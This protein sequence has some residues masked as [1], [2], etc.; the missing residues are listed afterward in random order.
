[1]T[2]R[3]A[4]FLLAWLAAAP[5]LS[6]QFPGRPAGDEVEVVAET[7]ADRAR[8][9][10]LPSLEH[11][12]P[13]RPG[14]R[15]VRIWTGLSTEPPGDELLLLRQQGDRV[16]GRRWWIMP[17][18]EPPRSRDEDA[19]KNYQSALEIAERNW[20]SLVQETG[21][22]GRRRRDAYEFCS[23]SRPNG[24]SWREL[25]EAL[26]SLGVWTLPDEAR[27]DP[28]PPFGLDGW[29][30]AVEVRTAA[31]YRRYAYWSPKS[32]STYPEVRAA[33]AIARV[34]FE[35]FSRPSK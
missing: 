13:L 27:L 28:P 8:L 31:S 23:R 18:P 35:A 6:A 3:R 16:T 22:G 10:G 9:L 2:R 29:T 20:Q 15:E 17:L 5:A 24:L 26:D 33:A 34:I 25:L 19:R 4:A 12:R 21:C 14:E 11:A 30:L 32:S 1:M 7:M